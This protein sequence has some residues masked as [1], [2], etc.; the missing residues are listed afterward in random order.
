[1]IRFVVGFLCLL[2]S[3]NVEAR[4][5]SVEEA[6]IKQDIYNLDITVDKDGAYKQTIESQFEIL[7]EAGR[8]EAAHY[9][10]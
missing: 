3:F 4:W 5:A 9:T 1:M 7:K 6:V 10:V 8:E 2:I